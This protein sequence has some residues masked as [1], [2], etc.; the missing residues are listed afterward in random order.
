MPPTLTVVLPALDEAAG[1]ARALDDAVASL[2]P[3][4]ACSMLGGFELVVVDDGS[5]DDTAALVAGRS[6]VEPRVR[7]I[8]HARNR[9]VGAALR[10]ALE[11]ADGDLLLSTDADMPVDLGEVARALPLLDQ[12]GVVLVAGR[13][14]TFAGEP[15]VRVTASAAYDALVHLL[16]GVTERDVN[17]PFKLART[18]TIRSLLLRSEGALIDVELLVRAERIGTVVAMDLDYHQRR[19]G[20]SKTM[21]PGLLLRLALELAREGRSLRGRAA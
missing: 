20:A 2:D 4:V 19:F 15:R 14:R 7:L 13:R 17:F 1:I 6:A 9:G 12:P 10:S 3:L 21:R 11:V 16:L 8:R 18:D 5:Q